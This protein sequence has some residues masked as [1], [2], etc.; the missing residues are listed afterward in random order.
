M[1]TLVV[2]GGNGAGL[3]A[4]SKAKRRNPELEVTVLEAGKDISYSACGIP[5]LIEG[6]V[7]EPEQLLVLKPDAAKERGLDVQLQTRALGFNPFTKELS[8]EGPK[9]RDALHYDKLCIATGTEAA[10]PFKG[11]DLEGVFTLR[12]L[13]DGVRLMEHVDSA[14]SKKVGIVGGGY[15]G[16]EMAEAFHKRGA[17]VHLLSKGRLLPHFDADMTDG[18]DLF[19]QERGIQV[20]A[21]HDVKALAHGKHKGHVGVIETN[22]DDVHVD[23]V[24][25]AVGVR[26]HT[27][28]ATKSGVHALS[29][30]HLLVDDQM[31][32]NL[33]DVWA[34][35][36]CVAPR[37]FITGRP[38]GVPL[39]LPANRM[40]RVAG[41]NIAAS[42]ERI[43]GP[44]MFFPG[45]LG[46][47]ITRIFGL[48]FAQTGLSEDAA[49]KDGFDVATSL[50]ESRNKAEYM[51][52]SHD[53]AIKLVGDRDSGK[54]LGAE[55]AGPAESVLRINA[56][57]VAIQAGLTV[58]KLAD[59]ETAYAPPFS[60]VWDPML[61]AASELGK[62][63]RK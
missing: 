6:I 16:L 2:V 41:D 42:T 38:T 26:P 27:A 30:G 11:G 54:L 21:N 20:Y 61:T 12:H 35:G 37:H 5:H 58:R 63:L 13:Q 15:L 47:A 59:V 14:K 29:S 22:K 9:G 24:L 10:N 56:A 34:A 45:V 51:P 17:E 49:K 53:M 7:E 19:L 8:I 52:E 31:R 3:S 46:T 33:H 40:G 36:D 44:S 55:I 43:P 57:A 39:A 50:V 4:A 28:F 1:T 18:L 60:P 25:V 32:T 23:A 62:D 48:G